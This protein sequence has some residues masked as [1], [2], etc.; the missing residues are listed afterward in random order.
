MLAQAQV[1]RE[2]A[3][4][5]IAAAFLVFTGF[6]TKLYDNYLAHPGWILVP[7]LAVAALVSVKAFQARSR[8]LAA[9]LCSCATILLVIATGLIG[10]FPNLIPSRMDPAASLTIANSS[11]SPYTLRLMAIVA[12]VFVPIV[13]V[14]QLFV[15]RFF[16]F[17]TNAEDSY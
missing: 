16:R 7:A 10:L 4:L 3:V 12:L 13:V 11:S 14:Y 6:A 5:V 1:R 15:Y 17:K 2:D 9:F 8:A